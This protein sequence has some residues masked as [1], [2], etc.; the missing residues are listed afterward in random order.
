MAYQSVR[1]A[2]GPTFRAVGQK[3]GAKTKRSK[4]GDLDPNFHE[5][6]KRVQEKWPHIIQALV[7]VE[8]DYSVKRSLFSSIEPGDPC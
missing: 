7:K 8:D 4:M 3:A 6:L 5:V 2:S 1:V